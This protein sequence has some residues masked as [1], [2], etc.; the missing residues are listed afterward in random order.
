MNSKDT[1]DLLLDAIINLIFIFN[2][3]FECAVIRFIIL[4]YRKINVYFLVKFTAL[5]KNKRKNKKYINQQQ[6]RV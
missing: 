1:S 6:K 4:F 3:Y 2:F 5:D